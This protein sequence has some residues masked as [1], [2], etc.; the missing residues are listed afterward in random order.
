M[1]LEFGV[2][3]FLQ[4]VTAYG[5]KGQ[6]VGTYGDFEEETR[7]IQKAFTET[8]LAGDQEGKPHLFPN[9]IYT[10]REETLKGDYE[11]DLHLVH[12]LS[13]NTDH[14]ISSI[15]CLITEA[16]WQII[17]DVEPVYKIIGLVTGNKT[18]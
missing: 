18:V 13:A 12:E 7:L 1:V 2:P 3:K 4:D 15:C 8:L 11:E 10:L 5:P 9:T 6:V 14:P 16:K 17:W